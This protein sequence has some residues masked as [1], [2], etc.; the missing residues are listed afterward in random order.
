[1]RNL[2]FGWPTLVGLVLASAAGLAAGEL[3]APA[4]ALADHAFN[5]ENWDSCANGNGCIGWKQFAEDSTSVGIAHMDN[6]GSGCGGTVD[7]S[8]ASGVVYWNGTGTV[9]SFSFPVSNCTGQS[10]PTVRVVPYLYNQGNNG[11]WAETWDYD[12]DPAY[13]SGS[14][15]MH[16]CWN[17]CSYSASGHAQKGYD[18]SEVYFNSYYSHSSAEWTWIAKHELGHVLGLA[19]HSCGYSGLMDTDACTEVNATTAE[20]NRVNT[21]HDH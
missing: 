7:Y 19:D 21:I 5:N 17:S 3:T 6:G 12:Q 9:A 16:A 20:K 4:P 11:H 8:W 2:L 10:Y 13:G 18:L 15:G 1:M 14:G